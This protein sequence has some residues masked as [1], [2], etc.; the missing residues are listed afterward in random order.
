MSFPGTVPA[1][2]PRPCGGLRLKLRFRQPQLLRFQP[3]PLRGI[4]TDGLGLFRLRAGFQPAPLRGIATRAPG[5]PQ[6]T[7]G[8]PTRAPAGDCDNCD[9]DRAAASHPSNPRPCGGLRL[10]EA[11]SPPLCASSNPRPCGGL[12]LEPEAPNHHHPQ[13]SN[14]RPCGG[15]RPPQAGH[16]RSPR[17][18]NPRP[19]GGLRQ[20]EVR[21]AVDD[22]PSNPRPCGG[23]RHRPPVPTLGLAYFQP[24]P[25]RGIAT[26]FW[27]A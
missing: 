23:L 16:G 9:R 2:N 3:A 17:P 11:L 6:W 27:V 18:S 15:L 5:Q 7:L 10:R 20:L 12:R 13:A 19:C 1:S 25:L 26:S 14:P 22:P 4:A 21:G 8:L 24:A